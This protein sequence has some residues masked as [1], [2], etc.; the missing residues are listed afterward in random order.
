M[1]RKRLRSGCIFLLMLASFN[2]PAQT[3]INNDG[4]LPDNSAILDIKS[5][6]QGILIPRIAL[7]AANVSSPVSSPANGLTIYN[8]EVSG[9]APNQV[10]PGTYFWN[11]TRWE[12]INDGITCGYAQLPVTCSG[13]NPPCNPA[14]T[15]TDVDGNIYAS[16][17]IGTQEWM[18]QNLKVTRYRDGA[19]IPNVTDNTSWS[20]LTSGA[21]CW[22]NNDYATHGS[23]YGALY[24]WHAVNNNG[25][26]NLCP[27]GWHVPSFSEWRTLESYLVTDPGG[28]M[29]ECGTA[30]WASPNGGATNGSC[31]SCLPDGYR[32]DTG[33]F[34]Y[35]GLNGYMWSSTQIDATFSWYRLITYQYSNINEVSCSKTTGLAVRCLKD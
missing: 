31:F 7:T 11:G 19:S 13:T 3:G 22:Y 9:N 6:S 29:K 32:D 34:W 23:I 24:N 8:T 10:C 25:S 28:K 14:G 27:A 1:K 30:H 26:N 12:R 17:I 2:L 35:V 21:Y 18:A 16:V 20:G 4:S 15:V 5:T 33:V